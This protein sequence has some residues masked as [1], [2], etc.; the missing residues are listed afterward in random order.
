MTTEDKLKKICNYDHSTWTTG[1]QVQ[2]MYIGIET[3][4]VL[5]KKMIK[6]NLRINEVLDIE[7]ESNYEDSQL[8]LDNT[9]ITTI[10]PKVKSTNVLGKAHTSIQAGQDRLLDDVI[11]KIVAET[12]TPL[13][14]LTKLTMTNQDLMQTFSRKVITRIM[15][16]SNIIATDGR[17]GPGKTILVSPK[18]EI[19][20]HQMCIDQHI[21]SMMEV[22]TDHRIP[23]GRIIVCRPNDTRSQGIIAMTTAGYTF[24]HE[25]ESYLSQYA[26]FE[27][28]M[29]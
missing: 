24:M 10:A 12:N 15:M 25:T 7:E 3:Q 21:T 11:N 13:P 6:R 27:Y 1:N 26:W 20:L 17:I 9:E 4:D 19:E 29:N 23:D 14:M 8:D 28:E 5:A 2:L 16:A 18:T 22:V